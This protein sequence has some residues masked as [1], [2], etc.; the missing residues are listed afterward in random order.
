MLATG[1]RGGIIGLAALVLFSVRWNPR[2][3]AAF[4]VGVALIVG[5]TWGHMN[6]TRP[7]DLERLAMW[8]AASHM[9]KD[10]P[11]GLGMQ[12]F[13]AVYPQYK[14][15]NMPI[16][17]FAH[18]IFF[19]LGADLGYPGLGLFILFILAVVYS[20]VK[21][22]MKTGRP[23]CRLLLATFVA[24]L[25]REMVDVS[26]I[27]SGGVDVVYWLAPGLVGALSSLEFGG[28]IA[29]DGRVETDATNPAQ[30][31]SNI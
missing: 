11:F 8:K 22:V 27:Y 1:S 31:G 16:R 18:N 10:H 5:L 15:P 9:M 14:A 24:I 3:L 6:C 7:Y 26:I 29:T 19:Q 12:G 20:G 25:V 21:L 30:I 4:V 17:H 13:N 28:E 2:R 23:L